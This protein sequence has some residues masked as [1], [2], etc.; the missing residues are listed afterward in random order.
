MNKHKEME[1][2]VRK[3]RENLKTQRSLMDKLVCNRL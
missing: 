3:E 1:D 2:W